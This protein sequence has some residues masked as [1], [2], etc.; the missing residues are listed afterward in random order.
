MPAL[1]GWRLTLI[2]AAVFLGTVILTRFVSLGSILVS[3]AFVIVNIWLANAGKY[4]L[5]GEAMPEF[6]LMLGV[7]AVMAIWRHRANIKRLLAGNEN[8]LKL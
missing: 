4:G 3:I 1:P 5:V 8:K 7:I 2:C 6:R